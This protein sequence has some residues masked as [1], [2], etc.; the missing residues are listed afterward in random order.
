M[1]KDLIKH[2]S[3][4]TGLSQKEARVALGIVLNATERQGSAFTTAL[5]KKMP[6]ART[7][8][9]RIGDETGAASGVIARLIEQTPGGRMSVA[10]NMIRNLQKKGL[11]HTEIAA[12]F[13]AISS[14]CEERYGLK[15]F[16]HL[17]DLLGNGHIEDDVKP[18]TSKSKSA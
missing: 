16:G 18:S 10:T 3:K 1:M 6:G 11:G 14:F 2:V 13:P 8:S 7:L 5:Y 17:G 4:A 15:G 12:I 9:A